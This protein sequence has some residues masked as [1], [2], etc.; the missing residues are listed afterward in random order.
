[1][2]SVFFK[3][4]TNKLFR[5]KKNSKVLKK[6]SIKKRGQYEIVILLFSL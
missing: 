6:K 1:M 4:V 2:I 5:K 3:F